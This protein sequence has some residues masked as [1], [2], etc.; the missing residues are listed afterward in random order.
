MPLI[1]RLRE[2]CIDWTGEPI[3]DGSTP[4]TDVHCGLLRE[5][6]DTLEAQARELAE[7]REEIERLRA[8]L[9]DG[10]RDYD[11]GYEAGA[12]DMSAASD[13]AIERATVAERSRDEA[14]EAL[15]VLHD[16][17]SRFHNAAL[18]YFSDGTFDSDGGL[19]EAD[20]ELAV[21]ALPGARSVLAQGDR[22]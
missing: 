7:A 19:S 17:A 10:T 8:D 22:G 16:A 18:P 9:E 2:P 14:L 13:A 12:G 11:G 3:V 6:A 5:A 15:R 1:E 21:V 4:R 20:A